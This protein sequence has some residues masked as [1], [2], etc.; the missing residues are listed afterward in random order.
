MNSVGIVKY[1]DFTFGQTKD[2]ALFLDCGKA[3]FP[4]TIR[5]ETYGAL[6]ETKSNAILIVHALTGNAHAAGYYS[7]TDKKP[8]W[9]DEMIGPGKPFDTNK[10][11]VVCSNCIGG[12]SGSTGPRSINPETGRKYNLTFPVITI[13][14]MARAQHKLMEH[15]QIPKWLNIAGGSMGGMQALQWVIDYPD[16]VE[17]ISAIATTYSLSPQAIAFDWVGREAIMKDPDWNNGEYEDKIPEK[18]LAIARMLAHITY[19]SDESMSNKFGRKLKELCDYSYDFS[20]NFEI[21][22]YLDYQGQRF[23][24][25]FDANSYLY[26]TRA[27]DYFDI[28]S[29][30]K[31]DL[32]ECFSEAK[33]KFLL[34]SF[35]SDWL[36]P[37]Q[38]S[39]NIVKA[40]RANNID[41]AYCNIESN[42]GHDAFLLESK[43][44]GTLIKDYLKSV[45]DRVR[46]EECQVSSPEIS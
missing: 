25:R 13:A 38:K 23:V 4:I 42:Y 3:L 11:Y 7:E 2:D 43:T 33:A 6:N 34:V 30:Q 17:S 10:Y 22:S 29:K 21:E 39:K 31:G 9:W 35:T 15:L 19:L 18:G 37:P 46:S 40:L 26:I 41:V 16:K 8:G 45:Y 44:L 32:T 27:M 12:C 36:F 28:A 1:H 5:Y 24:E 20:R 14:D